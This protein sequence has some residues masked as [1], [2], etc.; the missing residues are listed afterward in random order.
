MYIPEGGDIRSIILK[1]V[2]RALYCAHPGVEKMYTNMKK[3]FFWVGMKHDVSHF[4]GK[5]LEIQQVKADHHHPTGLLQLHDVPMSKWEVISMDFVVGLMLTSHRHN[6]ILVRVDKLT[7]SAHLIPVRET[8]DVT[9]VAHVFV[10]EVICLHEIP[11]KIISDRDSRFTSRFW[12]S[13]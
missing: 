1:E 6:A 9:N 11:K 12:T 4:I 10:S 8:Y 2:H 3:I 7:K 13:L 5:C